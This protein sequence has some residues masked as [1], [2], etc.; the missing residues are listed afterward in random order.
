MIFEL[1]IALGVSAAPA[2]AP[3]AS[4]ASQ[5]LN[6]AEHAVQ[7]QRLEQASLMVARA[8]TAG[9]TGPQLARVLADL[10][11]SKGNYQEALARYQ[12]LVGKAPNDVLLLERAGLAALK[13]G[14]AA[15]AS[16]YLVRATGL[17]HASWRA[18]NARG[19]VA[20][21][22]GDWADADLAYDRA[23]RIAPNQ[24][25][26]V[27]NRGWSLVLRGKWQE[28]LQYLEQA[29]KLDPHS[30]RIADNL[31]LAREALA[32]D[33]PR[34]LAGESGADWAVRL[35]DAGVAAAILGDKSRATAAFT[36]ALEA[37]GTW[38]ARAANNLELLKQP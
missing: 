33:L 7:K 22:K 9:A 35:N 6:D 38:Y 27:N 11:F 20:D 24:V 10:A 36:Q 15:R 29:S 1:L 19:V 8:I 31:E 18:W 13:L 37:S 23:S 5:L 2:P 32:A 4:D 12:S 28:S 26:P 16:P 34:R 14:D 25:E 30:K 21:M 17:S 3:A